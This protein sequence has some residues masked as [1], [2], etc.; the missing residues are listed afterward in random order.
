MKL[1][2]LVQSTPLLADLKALGPPLTLVVTRP[3]VAA[4]AKLTG[5]PDRVALIAEDDFKNG[6][7]LTGLP[8]APD[9][10]VNLSSSAPSLALAGRLRAKT[11]LGPQNGAQNGAQ[12]GHV[13]LSLPP[14]QRLA[15]AI[16]AVERPLGRLNLVDIWRLLSPAG[17]AASKST[18]WPLDPAMGLTE[19]LGPE[20]GH[21]LAQAAPPIVGLHLGSGNHLR[22]WPVERFVALAKG[23]PGATIALLGGASERSLARRFL[24]LRD[25]SDPP[26]ID[27]SGKTSLAALGPAIKKL[28]LFV[29][30][31]TGVM[32]IAAALG[33]QVLAVFGGPA[34]AGETGPYAPGSII[35]QGR[36]HCSPCAE[37]RRCPARPCPALPPVGP[38]LRAARRLL[39]LPDGPLPDPDPSVTV[40]GTATDALGQTLK[41]FFPTPLGPSERLA[42]AIREAAAASLCPGLAPN[43]ALENL[44]LAPPAKGWPDALPTVTAIAKLAFDAPIARKA[45]TEATLAALSRIDR[46]GVVYQA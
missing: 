2:D 18:L 6:P 45:F 3:E 31:D 12:N 20:L 35:V 29:S 5:L 15:A 36:S 7:S 19:A 37:S 46:A 28:N 21:A 34:L 1:G 38:V 43:P 42:H 25:P 41:G 23:L 16:M 44:P 13:G 40:Y 10:L 39:F 8:D 17:P 22:R 9:L 26:A 11:R 30:A 27:L 14:A 24:A 33:A 4:A 32:H